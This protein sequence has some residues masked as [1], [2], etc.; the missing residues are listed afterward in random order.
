[1]LI[2][3]FYNSLDYQTKY[4]INNFTNMKLITMPPKDAW[5]EI[6]EITEFDSTYGPQRTKRGLFVINDEV[7]KELRAQFQNNEAN[8]LKKLVSSLKSC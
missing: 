8:R 1:M 3:T 7:D 4:R 6:D 2:E 5:V